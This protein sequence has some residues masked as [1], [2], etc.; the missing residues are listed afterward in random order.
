MNVIYRYIWKSPSEILNMK[1]QASNQHEKG[2]NQNL[3]SFSF[4]R[5]SS[6]SLLNFRFDTAKSRRQ[7]LEV[8]RIVRY[9]V[10]QAVEVR[11]YASPEFVDLHFEGRFTLVHMRIFIWEVSCFLSRNSR[12]PL[13]SIGPT[14]RWLVKSGGRKEFF[15]ATSHISS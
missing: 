4:S 2:K 8:Y 5:P 7:S 1:Y 10:F 6:H 3:L 14:I 9:S 13:T 15:A 12:R 11:E